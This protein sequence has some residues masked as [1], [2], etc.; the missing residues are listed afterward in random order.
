MTA[1]PDLAAFAKARPRRTL[2]RI[3]E[4]WLIVALLLAA[5]AN[6]IAVLDKLI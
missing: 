1:P 3:P 2:L 4:A 5:L 6:A